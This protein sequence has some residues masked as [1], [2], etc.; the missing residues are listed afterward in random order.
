MVSTPVAR[1]YA[2]PTATIQAIFVEE[3]RSG[4]RPN[5]TTQFWTML[6]TTGHGA[7][8]SRYV[9]AA[10]QG[11]PARAYLARILQ[12]DGYGT[13]QHSSAADSRCHLPYAGRMCVA[14]FSI[15]RTVHRSQPRCWASL[16]LLGRS[17]RHVGRAVR[18]ALS[19]DLR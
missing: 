14:N 13:M 6:A 9:Y 4:G 18:A 15:W 8:S 10:E 2:G 11:R 5:K 19:D 16:Y 7:A 3:T 12:I 1:S 17:A